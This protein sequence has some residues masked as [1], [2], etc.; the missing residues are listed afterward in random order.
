MSGRKV[1]CDGDPGHDDM[2]AFLLAAKHLDLLGITTV[3]GNQSIEKVTKNALRVV[4]LGGITSIPVARGI[5]RPLV[6]LPVYAP[7]IHGNSGLD[8]HE[9]PEPTTK[10]ISKHAIDFIIDMVMANDDVTLVP[11]GPLTN[12]A[13]SLVTEPPAS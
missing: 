10:I 11:T 5:G 2:L 13:C 7:E 1:I 4:E 9:F 6:N 12:I 8:G 3:S